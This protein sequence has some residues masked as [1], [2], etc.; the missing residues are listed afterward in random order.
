MPRPAL[1][2]R[3]G[4]GGANALCRSLMLHRRTLAPT[5]ARA[6]APPPWGRAYDEASPYMGQVLAIVRGHSGSLSVIKP[7]ATEQTLVHLSP[8]RG[9]PFPGPKA[10]CG[11]SQTVNRVP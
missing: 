5:D 7:R 6:L 1:D 2:A 11:R 9:G 8:G 3:A 10:P 4:L